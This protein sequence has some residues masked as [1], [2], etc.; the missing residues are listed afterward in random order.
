LK[1]PSVTFEGSAAS[2]EQFP[3]G[4]L[5]EVAFLGRSNVGKSRLLNALCGTPGLARVSARP[6][7]TQLVN[8]FRMDDRLYLV[9]LPGYGYARVPEK[10][11]RGFES[12]VTS[13]LRRDAV[14]L[15]VFLVDARHDPTEDD[16][17]LR[18]FLDREGLPY[19]VAATKADKL[20]HGELAR[21]RQGLAKGLGRTALGVFPTSAQDGTGVAELLRAIRQAALAGS[22]ATAASGE[23]R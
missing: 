11:Q 10:V 1:K 13:Y 15:G 12:L 2:P 22:P 4:G 8:F 21:R 7:R 16:H 5:P 17:M 19:L 6:G 18:G 3:E 23:A 14:A 9:D 20:G